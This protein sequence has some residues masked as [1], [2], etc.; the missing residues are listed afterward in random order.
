MWDDDAPLVLGGLKQ[1]YLVDYVALL[2]NTH[3]PE[4]N[5]KDANLC[6]IKGRTENLPSTFSTT[7]LGIV[8]S[9]N[10]STI[11]AF[12]AKGK[13]I[14]G[15]RTVTG[16][17]YGNRKYKKDGSDYIEK[18]SKTG[19][20]GLLRSQEAIRLIMETNAQMETKL[21]LPAN[22]AKWDKLREFISKKMN[23][24]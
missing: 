1:N 6:Q 18:E 10:E 11:A 24:F 15:N 13:I 22:K 5:V 7:R 8:G 14:K 3:L 21:T 16:G 4:S 12:K 23:Q 9:L 2:P 19:V 17:M 20:D